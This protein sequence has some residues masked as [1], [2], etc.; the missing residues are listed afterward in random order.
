[1][2]ARLCRSS[3]GL[4]ACRKEKN[5]R[6]RKKNTRNLNDTVHFTAVEEGTLMYLSSPCQMD[7]FC[8]VD[9]QRLFNCKY[10]L[11]C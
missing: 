5:K 3:K 8:H 2:R 9:S 6:M 7:S 11:T 10:F 4:L 1:M